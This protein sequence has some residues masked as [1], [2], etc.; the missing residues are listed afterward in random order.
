MTILTRAQKGAQLTHAELDGNFTHLRD[1]LDLAV[2]KT[3]GEGIK[4]DSLGTRTYAW[5]DL[6]G[7]LYVHDYSALN[8][9]NFVTYK[10]GIRQNKFSINNETQLVFH[11]P[12]DYAPNT[13]IYIHAH[14]SHDSAFVNGGGVTW[15][16][17][18][19]YAKGHNQAFFSD[20]KIIVEYQAASNI[21]Y[22]HMIAEAVASTPGGGA[23]L[24]N[25]DDIEVDGLIFGRVYLAANNMTVSSGP[26]PDPFLHTVDIHY[27]S[28][29]V[30]TKQRFPDFWT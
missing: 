15:G 4:V 22:Q 9:P 24:L 13:N 5:H 6:T 3:K 17:E 29:T 8:S 19:S 7:T 1:G 10:N 25:T 2:P 30:G 27:Q 12:H 11:I 26:V 21:A 18:L 20:S 28:T 16:F 14:W 23:S